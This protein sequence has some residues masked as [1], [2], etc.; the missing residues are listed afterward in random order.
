MDLIPAE[1]IKRHMV[2][3]VERDG[4][5]LKVSLPGPVGPGT[6]DLLRFRL[7]RRGRADVAPAAKVRDYINRFVGHHRRRTVADDEEHRPSGPEG[8]RSRAG[9]AWSGTSGGGCSDHPADH[10]IIGE[11]RCVRGERYS[12][13]TMRTACGLRYRPLTEVCLVRDDVP[14]NMQSAV[15]T[16]LKIMA[17]WTSPERRVP[18]D[19]RI[20]MKIAAS[21]STFGSARARV[22]RR[23]HRAAYFCGPNRLVWV[24]R[25]WAFEHDSYEHFQRIIR[26]PTGIFW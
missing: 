1:L 11:R 14:K 17:A 26:R 4:T 8:S 13:G 19:G 9:T 3:P 12:R 16:R 24:S 21:R 18:Q 25:S 10:L 2:L 22:P 15:T 20:K 7:K 5:R 23:E 6:L